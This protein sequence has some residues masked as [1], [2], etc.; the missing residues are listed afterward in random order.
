MSTVTAVI[1]AGGIGKRF[2]PFVTDKTLFPF[3][4][5]SLLARTLSMVAKA[6]ITQVVVAANR[7]NEAWLTQEAPAL[8]PELSIKVGVQPQP[9]GMGDALLAIRS[10]LPSQDIL[11]MNAGDMVE[12]HLLTELLTLTPGKP[13][14]LT[15][16]V[17]P[18][19]QPLGYFSLNQAGQITGIQ[20]KPGADQMPSDLANL[21]FHYFHEAR[22]FIDLVAAQ[23]QIATAATDDV[24]EQALNRLIEQGGVEVYRY[25]GPWQKLKYGHHVLDMVNYL[26]QPLQHFI[27]PEAK[28]AAG[29]TLNGEVVIEAGAQVLDGA[30]I[31]GPCWI[32]PDVIIGNNALVRQSIVEAGTTIG[33]GCEIVR[34]YVGPQCDLHHA[35]IGDSVLERQVHFGFNAHTANYRLDQQ[36]IKVKW[37]ENE[38]DSSR[39]KLGA[40]IAAGTEIGVN[41][42]LMPG[43]CVGTQAVVYPATVVYDSVPD[44]TALKEKREQEMV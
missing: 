17:T 31:Q 27:S 21:V 5:Q 36:S 15:G 37:G 8:F 12:S 26:L 14:V 40:L 35:Y 22:Q 33:F 10:L 29:A 42:S 3:L 11:I 2:V 44:H 43:V 38:L 16:R 18:T 30:I 24:Y 34:S 1:L 23:Q 7:Y 9:Q 39:N 4:G 25:D 19:Y 20:E 32:G 13:A 41:T 6:G 28:I